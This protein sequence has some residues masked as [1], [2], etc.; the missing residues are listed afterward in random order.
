MMLLT[1]KEKLKSINQSFIKFI[2]NVL[3]RVLALGPVFKGL[4]DWAIVSDNLSVTVF[5][6]ARDYNRFD[7]IYSKNVL[8]LAHS[9]G[10]VTIDVYQ[11]DDC[12]YASTTRAKHIRAT[13][14][15]HKTA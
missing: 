11:A 6:L 8:D 10:F 3:F 2:C 5:I 13:S 1:G 7:A 9:M 14:S 4:Y 12:V 15:T